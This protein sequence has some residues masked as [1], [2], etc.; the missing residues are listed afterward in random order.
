[1]SLPPINAASSLLAQQPLQTPTT[2]PDISDSSGFSFDTLELQHALQRSRQQAGGCGGL[3]RATSAPHS[4]DALGREPVFPQQQ[5]LPHQ[6]HNS[7][8]NYLAPTGGPIRRVTSSLGLRR[9][10]S[11]FWT[12]AAHRDFERAVAVLSAQTADVSAPNILAEMSQAHTADLKLSDVEKHL[13]KRL[14]VQRRVLQQLSATEPPGSRTANAISCS[15]T[16]HQGPLPPPTFA[17][18][19]GGLPRSGMPDSAGLSGAGGMPLRA[20]GSPPRL[21]RLGSP[22]SSASLCAVAEEPT[23]LTGAPSAEGLAQQFEA[24]RVQHM[25]LW[26]ARAALVAGAEAPQQAA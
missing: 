11:F 25:Q 18:P 4:M 23:A 22:G 12:P 9:S 13:R 16:S 2:A 8:R 17:M 19:N 15:P 26:A 3:R 1:M 20:L 10:S 7:Q 6:Q 14:L 21:T 24:Q 5:Q